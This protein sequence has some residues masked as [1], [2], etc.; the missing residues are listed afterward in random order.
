VKIEEQA[1]LFNTLKPK[2][3]TSAKKPERWTVWGKGKKGFQMGLTLFNLL[4]FK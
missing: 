1:S 4:C 3:K 2:D